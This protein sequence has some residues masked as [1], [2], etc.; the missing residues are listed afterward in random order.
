LKPQ[1]KQ[2]NTSTTISRANWTRISYNATATELKDFAAIG[3]APTYDTEKFGVKG[4]PFSGG[5][6]PTGYT[7]AKDIAGS[8][9]T[10]Q[11]LRSQAIAV[12]VPITTVG[13][14]GFQNLHSWK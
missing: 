7:E 2:S 13:D 3:G 10:D 12:G 11:W 1:P 9:A 5:S 6:M 4:L 8:I 14:Y